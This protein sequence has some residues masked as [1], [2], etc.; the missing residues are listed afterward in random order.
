MDAVGCFNLPGNY[1]A[2]QVADSHSLILHTN[3]AVTL[4]TRVLAIQ[5]QSLIFLFLMS[6]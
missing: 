3:S 2:A 5:D 1:Q 6:A 4:L